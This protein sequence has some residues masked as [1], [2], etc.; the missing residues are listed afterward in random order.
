MTSPNLPLWK[1]IAAT[2]GGEISAGA[3]APGSRL[4]TEA[5]L[6][7][8]FGVNRHTVR[9]ALSDLAAQGAVRARRG[10]GVFV[11]ITPTDYAIGL[12]TRFHQNVLAS[13]RTPSRRML[14]LETRAAMPAEAEALNLPLGTLVHVVEGL[15]LVDSQPVALFRSVFPAA[16]FPGLLVLLARSDSVTAAL[17]ELGLQDYT[18]AQTRITATSADAVLAAH[19]NL[20]LHAPALQSVAINIDPDGMAIEYGTTFFAGE[21]VT[22]TVTP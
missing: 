18:R 12:R 14:R 1:T 7:A 2:L 21:R 13:G 22:L 6:S 8:R 17:K 20:P 15:S 4:P 19:L 10:A 9:H 5:Q 11:A 3:Y 16:R